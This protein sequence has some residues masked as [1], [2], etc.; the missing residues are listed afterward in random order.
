M[1][2]GMGALQET[3]WKTQQYKI[4]EAVYALLCVRVRV[5]VAAVSRSNRGYKFSEFGKY[6]KNSWIVVKFLDFALA[7]GL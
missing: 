5:L 4:H 2:E 6:G 3:S 1:L 7:N